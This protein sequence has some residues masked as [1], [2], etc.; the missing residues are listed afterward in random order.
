[1]RPCH[2]LF[3]TSSTIDWLPR[4]SY[5]NVVKGLGTAPE[6]RE[7]NPHHHCGTGCD[8]GGQEI[9]IDAFRGMRNHSSKALLKDRWA[10]A[11]AI[12]NFG[13]GQV[14]PRQPINDVM[15]Q[16]SGKPHPSGEGWVVM[17]VPTGAAP[18]KDQ[19]S[20]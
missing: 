16:A 2:L 18:S 9:G 1:M 12:G 11:S 17:S 8:L 6:T 4:M 14:S 7:T 19:S 3:S 10:G 20:I 13:R 5:H 15:I